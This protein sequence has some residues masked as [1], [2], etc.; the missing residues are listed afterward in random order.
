M[1]YFD[2]AFC[3]GCP[4]KKE[5]GLCGQCVEAKTQKIPKTKKKYAERGYKP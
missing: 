1:S 3:G 2:V 4:G 5:S